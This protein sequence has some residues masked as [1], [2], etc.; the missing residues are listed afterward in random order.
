MSCEKHQ[1]CGTTCEGVAKLE[2]EL[3]SIMSAWVKFR[4]AL[5]QV[6]YYNGIPSNPGWTED[7]IVD[8]FSKA[9]A[10]I[11]KRKRGKRPARPA[12]KR[13]KR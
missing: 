2:A 5:R 10:K 6:L 7:C 12:A 11:P 1:Q 13:R 4:Q 8:A 9:L 3:D